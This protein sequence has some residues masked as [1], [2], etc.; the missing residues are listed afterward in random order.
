MIHRSIVQETSQT[1]K[2]TATQQTQTSEPESMLPFLSQTHC[3][4]SVVVAISPSAY[5]KSSASI[6]LIVGEEENQ[7]VATNFGTI[8]NVCN[9][10]FGVGLLTLPYAFS[11][12]NCLVVL[13]HFL[14]LSDSRLCPHLLDV[15]P[16][17]LH[18]RPPRSCLQHDQSVQLS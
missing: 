1:P 13:L 6:N 17:H 2:Q 18:I 11:K 3:T 8:I 12:V 10:I 14:V 7:G 9:N 15:C 16:Q 4:L 5:R